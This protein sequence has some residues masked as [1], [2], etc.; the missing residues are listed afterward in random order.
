MRRIITDIELK[1]VRDNLKKIGVDYSK[2]YIGSTKDFGDD[3]T[4][5]IE[6]R[7]GFAPKVNTFISLYE[8][9]YGNKNGIGI[10]YLASNEEPVIWEAEIETL[11]GQRQMLF[12][13]YEMDSF[14]NRM[15]YQYSTDKFSWNTIDGKLAETFCHAVIYFQNHA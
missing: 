10:M 8:D 15:A 14:S 12:V 11:A 13:K 2:V 5:V 6:A 9:L 7:V 3:P 4:I 1:M